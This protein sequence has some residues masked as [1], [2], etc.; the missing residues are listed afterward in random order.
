MS[1]NG[2]FYPEE[3]IKKDLDQTKIGLATGSQYLARLVGSIVVLMIVNVD[4]QNFYFI[5]GAITA[6]TDCL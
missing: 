2:P 4:N 3:A 5:A 6:G 1:L